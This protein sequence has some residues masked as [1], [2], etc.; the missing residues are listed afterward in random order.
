MQQAQQLFETGLPLSALC[1]IFGFALPLPTECKQLLLEELDVTR[2]ARLLLTQ[3][4][5]QKPPAPANIAE[6][7]FPPEFSSN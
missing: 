4:D 3:L 1:D 2:R 6:R 5:K 7:H